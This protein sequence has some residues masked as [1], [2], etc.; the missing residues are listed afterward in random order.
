[1]PHNVLNNLHHSGFTRLRFYEDIV[2]IQP[3][4]NYIKNTEMP[5]F[6]CNSEGSAIRCQTT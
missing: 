1:M 2:T 4:L 6:L 5:L 3:V